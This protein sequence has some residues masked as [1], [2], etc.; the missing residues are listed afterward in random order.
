[1]T[2]E[3]KDQRTVVEID[4]PTTEAVITN[5]ITLVN[6]S[7]TETVLDITEIV[8]VVQVVDQQV[9]VEIVES[10]VELS[11]DVD[12]TTVEILSPVTDILTIGIQG[13]QGV[14]GVS[15][16]NQIDSGPFAV[17][18]TGVAD[19]ILIALIRSVK[20]VVTV[21]D[22]V[23]SKYAVYEVFGWHNG[24]I[25]THSR[26]GHQGSLKDL[27]DVAVVINGAAMELKVTNNHSSAIKVS[28]LRFAT[29]VA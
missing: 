13:P 2:V 22:N 12:E 4:D 8:N 3:I 26:Y 24:V 23:N 5:D 14:P 15:A 18:A 28:V 19:S 17:S 1:M 6:I 21:I 20:W 29:E 25:A 9:L 27:V 16:Q 10:A 7:N 11:I